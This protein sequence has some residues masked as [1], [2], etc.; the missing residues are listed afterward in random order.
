MTV[1]RAVAW[2]V[3][4]PFAG[5]SVL[6]GHR[7]AYAI[8]GAPAD[9]LHG[10]LAHAPQLFAVLATG[11]VLGLAA[12]TRARRRSPVPLAVV[13]VVAFV[14]Q[15]HLERLI[16]TGHVPFL[17]TSP[18]LWL[19]IAL[20]LP[21]AVAIWLIARRMAESLRSMPQR[22]RPPRADAFPVVF[23]DMAARPAPRSRVFAHPGRGPPAGL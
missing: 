23:A 7:I 2:F 16:H 1:R 22:R 14:I 5:V 13:G 15:E 6:L 19:G 20:Q 8:A 21:L 4:V 17:L 9:N 11:A 3:V 18:T 10:Y 12:D